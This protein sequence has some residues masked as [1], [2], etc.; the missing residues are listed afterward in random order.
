MQHLDIHWDSVAHILN[1]TLVYLGSLPLYRLFGIRVL[2][3]TDGLLLS[4]KGWIRKQFTGLQTLFQESLE[5]LF[6]KL[7]RVPDGAQG[8]LHAVSE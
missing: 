3:H 1:M 7:D 4:W 5:V 8:C 2:R 6:P